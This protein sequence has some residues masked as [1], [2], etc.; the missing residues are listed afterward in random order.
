LLS[1]QPVQRSDSARRFGATVAARKASLF[2]GVSDADI[3]A[4]FQAF[5][6]TL[7]V[8]QL[9]RLVRRA[10]GGTYPN[11]CMAG[12]CALNIKWNSQVRSAGIFEHVW[13]LPLPMTPAQRSARRAAS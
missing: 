8:E 11:L 5:L 13:F 9:D 10:F 1:D 4:T 6:G 2:A 3:I 7:I 12:G